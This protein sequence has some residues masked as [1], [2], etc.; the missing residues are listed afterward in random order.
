MLL[1][2][3]FRKKFIIPDFEKF[4]LQI[5]TLYDIAHRQEGGQVSARL[6]RIDFSV[7]VIIFLAHSHVSCL[8]AGG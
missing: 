7:C 2:K 5:D 6:T 1:T 4:V 8:Y 3:A